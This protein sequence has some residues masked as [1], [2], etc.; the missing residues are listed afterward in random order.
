MDD[1][2]PNITYSDG[3]A[4]GTSDSCFH[5]TMQSVHMWRNRFFTLLNRSLSVVERTYEAHRRPSCS[6]ETQFPCTGR[7]RPIT[8]S[9]PSLWMEFRRL[10][11][12]TPQ[13]RR[14]NHAS[15]I[16]WCVVLPCSASDVANVVDE[17]LCRRSSD[18]ITQSNRSERRSHF[19]VV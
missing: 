7:Q 8:V 17:V 5:G 16:Y 15:N 18:R 1:D 6:T 13:L 14:T 4:S 19:T 3:W 11:C 2:H 10:S 9:S 12:S